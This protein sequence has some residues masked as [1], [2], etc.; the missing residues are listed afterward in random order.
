MK[1]CCVVLVL[2]LAAC[3]GPA[4][5][6]VTNA[7][8]L[9]QEQWWPY[10]VRMR[11]S[12][13]APGRDEPLPANLTGVLIRVE[14]S[15]RPRIDFGKIGKYEIPPEKTDIADRSN[16]IRL[17]KAQKEAPNFIYAIRSRMLDPTG[18]A[19]KP[20]DAETVTQ[21]GF[22]CVYA[23]PDLPGF[24]AMARAL[25][26]KVPFL[27][28]VLSEPYTRT[29]LPDGTPFPYVVLQTAEG[30]VLMQGAW[31]PELVAKLDAELPHG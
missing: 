14:P 9:E 15:G 27:Y 24:D 13:Q 5:D 2:A 19:V 25:E 29:L 1:L 22:L 23:D 20:L 3:S 11:E 8:L 7:N 18:D 4:D 17:G 12:W 31:S 28:D 30:R 6:G 21:R 10:R 16:E 26:W